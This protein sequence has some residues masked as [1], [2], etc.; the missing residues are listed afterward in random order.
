MFLLKKDSWQV[1]E[2]GNKGR[3]IFAKDYIKAGTVISDYLGK[4]IKTATYN[5]DDDRKGLYLMYFT[6]RMS[7]YPDLTKPGPHLINHSCNPNCWIY[8]FHGHTLFFALRTINPDEE[9]TISYLLCPNEDTCKPCLHTCLC[10]ESRC[11]H[12]MHLSEV[13]YQAWQTFQS[14]Q[15]KKTKIIKL[16]QKNTLKKLSYYPKSIPTNPIY[17]KIAS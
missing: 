15:K 16:V 1:K 13:K 5:L 8:V 2:T 12:T 14:L 9:L 17:K 4:V 6:D 3:G 7:I 10:G 11:T